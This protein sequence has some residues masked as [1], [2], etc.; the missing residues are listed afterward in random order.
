MHMSIFHSCVVFCFFF[1]L[2]TLNCD[3][4]KIKLKLGVCTVN[5]VAGEI[6]RRTLVSYELPCSMSYLMFLLRA[7]FRAKLLFFSPHVR[8]GELN[9]VFSCLTA[10]RTL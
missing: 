6:K 4:C 8:N 3:M 10:G 7:S 1:H 5:V 2:K 9:C